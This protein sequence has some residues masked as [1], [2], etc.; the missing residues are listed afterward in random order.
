MLQ[1]KLLLYVI[2]TLSLIWVALIFAG[3]TIIK[4][5]INFYSNSQV[6]ASNVTVTPRL[7]IRISRLD[8]AFS[9]EDNKLQ[10]KGFSRSVDIFWSFSNYKPLVEVRVGPTFIDNNFVADNFAIQTPS[11]ALVDF[12]EIL[13]SAVVN[14][15]ETRSFGKAEE[16]NL[17]ATY[18]KNTGLIRDLVFY[19]PLVDFNFPQSWTS[20]KVF[21]KIQEVNPSVALDDQTIKI[22][23]SAAVLDSV[24]DNTKL[25]DLAGL[26]RVDG[27]ELSFEIDVQPYEFM[28]IER[29][30]GELNIQGTYS[31]SSF[32]K[33]FQIHFLDESSGADFKN[34]LSASLDASNNKAGSYDLRVLGALAPFDLVVSEKF[35]G[36]IPENKF[37]IDMEINSSELQ[38]NAISKIEMKNLNGSNISGNGQLRAEFT[39]LEE[40]VNCLAIQCVLSNLDADYKFTDGHHWLSGKSTCYAPPCS[41]SQM[42]HIFRTSNTA[43]IFNLIN[44]LKILNP[45]YSIYLYSTIS[46]G[47]K[48]GNGHEIII[49]S[50]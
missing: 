31:K 14:N 44:K 5:L 22:E 2:S 38:V 16:I 45:L 50:H 43:E 25:R 13:L 48:I 49:N 23:L 15:L 40:I 47:E 4:S 37:Q 36:E 35:V 9:S 7:D 24:Q 20:K 12:E 27:D 34:S 41:F 33:N 8:Y 18:Q 10:S 11:F 29:L 39:G 1:L 19:L 6:V 26:V 17:E 30:P 3:P 21:A 46:A 32:L 42:S 28:N